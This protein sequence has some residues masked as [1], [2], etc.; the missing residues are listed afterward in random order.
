[1]KWVWN[2]IAL[3]LLLMGTVWILQGINL[4]PGSFMTGNPT[5]TIMGAVLAVI[6]VVVF[7]L[8]NRRGA[9]SAAGEEHTR[10]DQ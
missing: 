8:A 10:D 5:W 7:Y 3:I 2:F 1:M 6:S 4:L 9:A